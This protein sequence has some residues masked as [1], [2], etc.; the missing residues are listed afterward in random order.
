MILTKTVD[1][2]I[3]N[4]NINHYLSLGYNVKHGDVINI[5]VLHLTD[6]SHYRID[7]K[8]NCCGNVK[9]IT[10]Q[11]YVGITK[12]HTTLYY[13]NICVKD[14]KTKHTLIRIY[15]VDNVSK[16]KIIKDRKEKTNIKNWGVTN[17]FQSEIIKQKLFDTNT[18]KYGFKSANQNDNILLK[19]KLTRIKNGNQISNDNL[20]EFKK[21]N[22]QIKSLTNKIKKELYDNWNGYDYYDNEY[23][24]DYQNLNSNHINY[25]TIDHKISIFDGFN[26]NIDINIISNIDNLCITK[27]KINCSKNKKSHYD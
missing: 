17:V 8:C 23:I 5:P 16:S 4:H 10:Y 18:K 15:G 11:D 6:G 19:S 24:K 13:C 20:S 27:R 22:K 3:I 21:Y 2:K 7:V 9:N 14:E 12:K 26:K 1:V 25:P